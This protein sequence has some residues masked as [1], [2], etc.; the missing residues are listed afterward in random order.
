M[1]IKAQGIYCELCNAPVPAEREVVIRESAGGGET[2]YRAAQKLLLCGPHAE[3]VE[4]NK[5]R[6][7]ALE[8]M[9][10]DRLF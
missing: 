7:R 5:E 4:A 9:D 3:S 8:K 10:Q 2:P 1:T 6:I